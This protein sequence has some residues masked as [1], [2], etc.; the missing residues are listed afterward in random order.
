MNISSLYLLLVKMVARHKQS[1]EGPLRFQGSRRYLFIVVLDKSLF[2]FRT[3]DFMLTVNI[4]KITFSRF[5]KSQLYAKQLYVIE[6][7]HSFGC[8][9]NISNCECSPN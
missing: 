6:R 7:S 8:K 2:T 1:V 9:K 5:L 3:F 4:S